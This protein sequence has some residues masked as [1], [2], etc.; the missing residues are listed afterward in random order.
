[1]AH[2]EGTV[3]TRWSP[4]EVCAYMADFSSVATWDPSVRQARRLD[5]GLLA[6]GARFAVTLDFMGRPLEMIYR[7]VQYAPPD[8]VVL[9]AETAIV[10]SVDTITVEAQA[11][12]CQVVY[13]AALQFRGFAAVVDLPAHLWFQWAGRQA[14]QGLQTA[15]A[16][17]P[18]RRHQTA[19]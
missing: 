3:H 1:M 7:L 9:E 5:A 8:R 15:L 18:P 2:F 16:G 17:E 11:E 19:A 12:G 10:R 13:R 14:L 6:E 4:A